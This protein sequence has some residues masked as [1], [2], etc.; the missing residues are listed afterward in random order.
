MTGR[1]LDRITSRITNGGMIKDV[2]TLAGGTAASQLISVATLPV[3]TRFYS[4][5]DMGRYGLVLAFLNFATVAA[6]LRYDS[7]VLT[8]KRL[9][10]AAYLATG[11]LMLCVPVTALASIV[12]WAMIRGRAMGYGALPTSVVPA[13]A[14]ALLAMNLFSI[15]R[16]LALRGHFF[17]AVS[18]VTVYQNLARAAAQVVLGA[19]GAGWAGLVVGEIAGRLAGVSTLIRKS[20]RYVRAVIRRWDW[21]V[22]RDTLY[23]YRKFPL[24]SLPSSIIDTSTVTL[25]L[26]LV[27]QLYGTAAAGQLAL[28]QRA[29]ALPSVLIGASFADAFHTKLAR[30]IRTRP[31]EARILFRDTTRTI[32]GIALIPTA[33]LLACGPIA[34]SLVFGAQWRQAGEIGRA[35][36]FSLLAQLVVSPL[37]RAVFVLSGQEFKLFYDVTSLTAV[38]AVFGAA[39]H[40]Q[41]GIV[42]AVWLLSGGRVVSY[43]VYYW[44]LRRLVYRASAAVPQLT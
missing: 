9:T 43:V 36:A 1:V 19:S 22:M 2:A 27:S 42:G 23:A 13:I 34:F 39:H 33:V 40:W 16:S 44:I 38:L 7:A 12:V 5:V 32:L 28:A 24:Y 8:P 29:L 17:T 18:R 14:V 41:I 31:E 21:R 4:P 26:P 15:F 25:L 20:G 37:S 10:E 3:V 11:A 35:L 6:C 30:S